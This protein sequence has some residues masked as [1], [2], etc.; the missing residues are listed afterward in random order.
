MVLGW[1]ECDGGKTNTGQG[2]FVFCDDLLLVSY[3]TLA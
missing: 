1:G 2:A 3:C